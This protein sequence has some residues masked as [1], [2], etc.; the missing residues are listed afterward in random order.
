MRH[1]AK[2]RPDGTTDTS[3]VLHVKRASENSMERNMQLWQRR[4]LSPLMLGA[5]LLFRRALLF[6]TASILLSLW[7]PA[8][9]RAQTVLNAQQRW[10]K[11]CEIRQAKFDQV[12]PAVMRESHID[13]WIV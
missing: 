4:D 2:T 7:L 13:M 3:P 1:P 10:Q 8:L 6:G 9:A 12:L 11:L 5:R